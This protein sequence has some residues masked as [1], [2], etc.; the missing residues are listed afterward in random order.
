MSKIALIIFLLIIIIYVLS[1]LRFNFQHFQASSISDEQ[2]ELALSFFDGLKLENNEFTL[3]DKPIK[4]QLSGVFR[5]GMWKFE[6]FVNN[7]TTYLNFLSNGKVH[8]FDT[9]ESDILSTNTFEV[10][11]SAATVTINYEG[12]QY[13]LEKMNNEKY[14][15]VGSNDIILTKMK[16]FIVKTIC[17][18]RQGIECEYV[19]NEKSLFYLNDIQYK[20][21]YTSKISNTNYDNF[22]SE[23]SISDFNGMHILV[24]N[25]N[26][27][28]HDFQHFDIWYYVDEYLNAKDYLKQIPPGKIVAVNTY[29]GIADLGYPKIILVTTGGVHKAVYSLN[30]K[31]SSFIDLTNPIEESNLIVENNNQNISKVLMS[32]GIELSL[33]AD[34]LPNEL[35]YNSIGIGTNDINV[36][37]ND[38]YG[39]GADRKFRTYNIPA[40]KQTNFKTM[41]VSYDFNGEDKFNL[42]TKT[43]RNPIEGLMKIGS[44]YNLI[45]NVGDSYSIIGIKDEPIGN[46]TETKISPYVKDNCPGQFKNKVIAISE[47]FDTSVSREFTLHAYKPIKTTFK[48][49]VFS[50]GLDIEKHHGFSAFYLN[51]QYINL[52]TGSRGINML[53]LN[54]DGTKYS[55]NS[56]DTHPRNYLTTSPLENFLNDYEELPSGS[57]VCLSFVDSTV[58]GARQF[59]YLYQ[60][61]S[62]FGTLIY[63]PYQEEALEGSFTLNGQYELIWDFGFNLANT[64]PYIGLVLKQKTTNQIS[65]SPRTK[66]E[67]YGGGHFEEDDKTTITYSQMSGVN[68]RYTLPTPKNINSAILVP[69][70]DNYEFVDIFDVIK[71][72]GG[73]PNQSLN[74]RC[75]FAIIGKKGAP[76]NTAI[77]QYNEGVGKI[78][79]HGLATISSPRNKIARASRVFDL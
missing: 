46:A 52:Q 71:D 4:N 62:H 47:G 31:N 40:N 18:A 22:G 53:V 2:L 72:I 51:D 10:S 75:D 43:L 12:E 8:S 57:I 5:L 67:I 11:P 36:K 58:D 70:R 55:F 54:E 19:G 16:E 73:S 64:P 26:G 27:S 77:Y 25:K 42:A 39:I 20:I 63:I 34:K 9:K 37:S 33:F 14:K 6:D 41:K 15:I 24:L 78:D 65:I 21:K 60:N 35:N 56:Y 13:E 38:L 3:Y 50:K 59:A 28:I 49:D 1:Y 66:L 69:D 23:E 68:K 32:P 29:M 44:D 17:S 7:K 61:N 30:E 79:E 48:V 76:P 45:L 74:S